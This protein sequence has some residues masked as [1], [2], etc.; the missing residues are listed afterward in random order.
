MTGDPLRAR[1]AAKRHRRAAA[2][3]EP[4]PPARLV[5]QGPRSAPPSRPEMTPDEWL[6]RTI[7]LGGTGGGGWVR[8][9]VP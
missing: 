2:P 9:T 6:R 4:P 5:T 7:A 3:S 1:L 8:M